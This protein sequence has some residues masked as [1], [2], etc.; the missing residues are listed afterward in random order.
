MIG[1]TYQIAKI[2]QLRNDVNLTLIVWQL[3]DVQQC[4]THCSV[5]GLNILERWRVLIL[6][7]RRY[8]AFPTSSRASNASQEFFLG[9][10]RLVSLAFT[11]LL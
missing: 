2:L 1:E 5:V 10:Q 3:P 9:L 11:Q 6:C 7:F 8:W 4:R